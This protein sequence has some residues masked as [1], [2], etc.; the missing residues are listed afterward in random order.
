MSKALNLPSSLAREAVVPQARG[1]Q[2][3]DVFLSLYCGWE[4]CVCT[5]ASMIDTN[6][7]ATF[8][9][10]FVCLQPF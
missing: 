1:L 8:G 3:R 7:E 6:Q 9:S 2:L 10:V 4:M 5:A